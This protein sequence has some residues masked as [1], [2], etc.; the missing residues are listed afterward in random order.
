MP[1]FP[2]TASLTDPTNGTCL[3]GRLLQSNLVIPEL[4]IPDCTHFP[5]YTGE[6]SKTEQG[7]IYRNSLYNGYF[8]CPV[9]PGL[10]VF[11]RVPS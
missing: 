6:L 4:V 7:S 5:L 8:L 2:K 10:T 1:T 9:Y 3:T 11:K